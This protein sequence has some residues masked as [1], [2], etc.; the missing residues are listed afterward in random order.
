MTASLKKPF[1]IT[2]AIS[3]PNGQPH[4]GHAYEGIA[5]DA[6]AR[7]PTRVLAIDATALN[8]LLMDR[9]GVARQ[10][11]SDLAERLADALNPQ[12]R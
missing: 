5:T 6:I 3:Y 9:P 12:P 11:V 4:I 8:Q 2:T 1:Y 7:G 10:I